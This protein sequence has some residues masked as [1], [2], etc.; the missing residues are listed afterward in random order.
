M[1]RVQRNEVR[2]LQP[3]SGLQRGQKHG[4]TGRRREPVRGAL[5]SFLP[6]PAER[7]LLS[8]ASR[9]T[10]QA[11][12]LSRVSQLGSGASAVPLGPDTPALRHLSYTRQGWAA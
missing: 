5:V 4:R 12:P 9:A 10:T 1:L 2:E 8:L 7:L 6:S 3:G 11:Q